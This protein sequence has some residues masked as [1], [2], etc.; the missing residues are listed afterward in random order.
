MGSGERGSLFMAQEP[1][2]GLRDSL[3]LILLLQAL[4]NMEMMLLIQP[5][6]P[7]RAHTAPEGPEPL[8][9]TALS[10]CCSIN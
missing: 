7:T 10:C 6:P 1:P 2:E 8:Q 5:V 3:E 9:G 4:L